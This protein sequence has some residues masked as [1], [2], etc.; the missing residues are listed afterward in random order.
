MHYTLHGQFHSLKCIKE[1]TLR[2]YEDVNIS[3]YIHTCSVNIQYL[4]TFN[5]TFNVVSDIN[6]LSVI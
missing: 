3:K 4:I 5:I 6:I 1:A 2:R